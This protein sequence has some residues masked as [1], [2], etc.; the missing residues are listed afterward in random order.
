MTTTVVGMASPRNGSQTSELCLARGGTVMTMHNA[1]TIPAQRRHLCMNL[2][3]APG[4][5]L[6][7]RA[8]D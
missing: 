3:M 6:W 8:P 2:R 7:W 4:I 1:M 5:F